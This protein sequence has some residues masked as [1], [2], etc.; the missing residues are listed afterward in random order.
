MT[1]VTVLPL[2]PLGSPRA[3]TP[4]CGGQSTSRRQCHLNARIR[5]VRTTLYKRLWNAVH[6]ERLTQAEVREALFSSIQHLKPAERTVFVLRDVEGLSPEETA[7][8]LETSINVVKHTLR[9]GRANLHSDLVSR[10]G[11][12]TRL[13]RRPD[14]ESV[15]APADKAVIE[16]AVDFQKLLNEISAAKLSLLHLSPRQFEELVAEIWD[17]FGYQ[18]ELTK[19]TRDGGRD[20]VAVRKTEAEMKLLIECKR[21][22]SD[23]KVGVSLVRALYGVKTHEGASKA[24]LATTSTFTKSASE[25][26]TS[27]RWELEGRD[28]DGVVG[29]VKHARNMTRRSKSGLWVPPWVDLTDPAT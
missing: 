2:S 18:V 25:F 7:A 19:R 27:H 5:T 23:N 28:Y 21:Y 24:I 11:P 20:I 12:I 14:A 10:L 22:A 8:A 3:R 26:V 4:V 9:R 15:L 29:W 13:R 6:D 1:S 17:R 16:A